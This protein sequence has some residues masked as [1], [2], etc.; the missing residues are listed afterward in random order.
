MIKR[1]YYPLC[2]SLNMA[3]IKEGGAKKNKMALLF[4]VK[5]CLCQAERMRR[6]TSLIPFLFTEQRNA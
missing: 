3:H 4:E 2:C 1:V 5:L 6:L